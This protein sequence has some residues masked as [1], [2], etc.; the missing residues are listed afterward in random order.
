M[1]RTEIS[2]NMMTLRSAGSTTAA[3]RPLLPRLAA[4]TGAAR[5]SA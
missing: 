5:N 4:A 2:A 1:T 3:Q